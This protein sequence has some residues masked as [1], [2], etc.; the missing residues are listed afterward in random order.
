[1]FHIMPDKTVRVTSRYP[2]GHGTVFFDLAKAHGFTLEQDGYNSDT[3]V[4]Q[5]G[6][7]LWQLHCA[8][9]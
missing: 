6:G 3:L 8:I 4:L 9:R 7:L 5:G 1:M 2:K